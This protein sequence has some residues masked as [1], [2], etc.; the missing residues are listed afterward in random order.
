MHIRDRETY[1]CPDCVG[2]AA[3]KA[4]IESEATN[5]ECSFCGTTSE[6]A[7][8]A[9]LDELISQIRGCLFKE[10]D[11]PANCLSYC[12][13]DGGWQGETFDSYDILDMVGLELPNDDDGELLTAILK[14]LSDQLWCRRDPYGMSR[15][16]EL[17]YSWEAFCEIIKHQRRFF[18]LD[19]SGGRSLLTP[20]EVL[21]TIFE[22]AK[23]IGLVRTL[24]RDRSKLFRARLQRPGEVLENALQLGPPPIE[25][26]KQ[27]R[28]SPAGIVMMYVS[29][30]AATA[31]AETVD[32]EGTY[33]VG[34]FAIE[35]DA[36][37]LDLA[38]LPPTP[39]IFYEVPDSMEYDPRHNLMFLNEIAD[40]I[41]RPIAR[42]DRVHVEYVPTQV[43]TEFIRTAATSNGKRIDGIAYR[44]SRHTDKSSMVLF[45]DQTNLVIP[46]NLQDGSY[47]YYH[48]DHWI[49]LV[50]KE[51]Y[52]ITNLRYDYDVRPVWEQSGSAAPE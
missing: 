1:V 10:Y 37:I 38:E 45:A 20:A 11:D 17:S 44:S 15:N 6:E 3:L 52:E 7:I 50:G 19:E 14:G 43:V 48:Q 22:Y 40:E 27:N 51:D 35:R 39:S 13:A 47:K 9:P 16:E 8:A 5:E 12:T 31:L 30:D 18:F 2:D 21:G 23:N 46:E 33:V 24:T 41:S 49:R 32:R 28:M 34:E 25:A 26:A 36:I 4:F 42:D 29:E